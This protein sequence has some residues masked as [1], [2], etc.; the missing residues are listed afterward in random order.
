MIEIV[1]TGHSLGGSYSALSHLHIL[2]KGGLDD[3]CK[4]KVVTFGSPLIFSVSDGDPDSV[5][6]AELSDEHYAYVNADDLV[7]SQDPRLLGR[8]LEPEASWDG[9]LR[10]AENELAGC[11]T[12]SVGLATGSALWAGHSAAAAAGRAVGTF[13]A[14]QEGLSRLRSSRL[15]DSRE[16]RSYTPVGQ[17]R[18]VSAARSAFAHRRDGAALANLRIPRPGL[19][20]STR[21]HM[22]S[23]YVEA[24]EMLLQ[25]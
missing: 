13:A 7:P 18:F 17:F 21:D 24:L 25:P 4:I 14:L 6:P 19:D 23:S 1:F 10:A 20:N 3:R 11:F 16:A 8:K 15:L 9:Y 12:S 22:P 2:M 5:I